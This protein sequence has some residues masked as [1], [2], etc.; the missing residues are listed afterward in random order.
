MTEGEILKMRCLRP[1]LRK[2]YYIFNSV[3]EQT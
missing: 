3:K 1:S 2:K